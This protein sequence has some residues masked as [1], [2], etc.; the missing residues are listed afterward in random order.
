MCTLSHDHGVSWD[1][2]C[3]VTKNRS[4]KCNL[5]NKAM[6]IPVPW[7]SGSLQKQLPTCC[8]YMLNVKSETDQCWNVKLNWVTLL[9]ASPNEVSGRRQTCFFGFC[10]LKHPCQLYCCMCLCSCYTLCRE[11]VALR[12][13]C[14]HE[15][16]AAK[17]AAE[18]L[19]QCAKKKYIVYTSPGKRKPFC[20]EQQACTRA[21]SLLRCK[22]LSICLQWLSSLNNIPA[23]S[24]ATRD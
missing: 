16:I 14:H 7:S 11:T 1:L 12:A 5:V 17:T 20:R 21:L 24:N 19:K 23:P 9:S 10:A 8:V 22:T 6:H 2:H 3:T 4:S 15:Q 18:Q 13:P